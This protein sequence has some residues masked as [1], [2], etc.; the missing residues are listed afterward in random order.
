[1]KKKAK[2]TL[3]GAGPGDPELITVKGLRAIESADAILYDALS[4]DELLTYA[5]PEAE[6]IYVGKR[7][8]RHS[9]QQ[10][11]INLLIVQTA[12][13]HGHVVR[14]KGGD[15]FV[16]GRGHEELTY[17]RAF[18]IETELVP[19]ITSVT[20]L[21]LLQSVPLTKRGISESFWVLTGTT[22]THD[23]SQDIYQAVKTDA[24]L[25]ILMG[26][27]KLAQIVDLL[28]TEGKS[29]IPV[30][31]VQNGSRDDENLV[32]APAHEIVA[33]AKEQMTT[34]PGIIIIGDV[35]ALHPEYVYQYAQKTWL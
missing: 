9:L 1:M 31:I 20:S 26:T 35:V 11:E 24:T 33:K 7:C 32:I 19:G 30:M 34:G 22:K 3:V 16:F 6:L 17:L 5:K 2:V 23:L 14:L 10:D 15:P 29:E 21:P 18:D 12:L 8:G 25:V 28:V 13:R 4:S 27:R